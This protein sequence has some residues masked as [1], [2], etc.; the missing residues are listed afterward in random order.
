MQL[1]SESFI[2]FDMKY[3]K[4]AKMPRGD[5][6][7]VLR[8]RIPVPP[9]EVQREV[10]RILDEYTATHD[11]LVRQL[12]EEMALREQQLSTAQKSLMSTGD[13]AEWIPLKELCTN[14]DSRRKPVTKSSREPGPYPYYGASGIVDY[15][16]GYLFD[17]EFLLVAEDGANLVA[18]STPI[19]FVA[20]GK[21]WVNNHAHILEFSDKTM[22]AYVEMYLNSIDLTEFITGAAQPK[23]SQ[24][25]LNRIPIPVPVGSDMTAM[26]ERLRSVQ[27][28]GTQL[29]SVLGDEKEQLS[30][31]LS[32]VRNQLL[33]FPEKVA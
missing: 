31:Q 12:E 7:A 24:K 8:Y 2:D 19:A 9:I 6:R 16:S 13:G 22:Q 17:G 29:I 32:L 26:V 14:L 27:E 5:K 4:G 23:L 3:A 21:T 30:V 1:A 20:A 10:V 25:N 15:V 33:S 28:T 11:E 18:R